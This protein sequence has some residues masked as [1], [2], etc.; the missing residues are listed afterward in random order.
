MYSDETKTGPVDV[1]IMRSVRCSTLVAVHV[2]YL[3]NANN[4][5]S[6]KYSIAY[7]RKKCNLSYYMRH[8]F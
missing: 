3:Q 4:F 6:V 5:H 7:S 8:V 1:S 2:S